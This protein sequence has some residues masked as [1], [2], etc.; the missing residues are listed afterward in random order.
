MN[1]GYVDMS[2]P[3]NSDDGNGDERRGVAAT[4]INSVLTP[5]PR[6]DQRWLVAMAA[7]HSL[8]ASASGRN[9]LRGNKDTHLEEWNMAKVTLTIKADIDQ[10]MVTHSGWPA[11]TSPVQQPDGQ[12]LPR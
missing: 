11:R 2:S 9:R 12:I 10:V 3:T 6:S 1:I 4:M 7:L 8:A 5:T